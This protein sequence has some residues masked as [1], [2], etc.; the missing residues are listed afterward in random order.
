MINPT[1]ERTVATIGSQPQPLTVGHFRILM[2]KRLDFV[3]E[4]SN[5]ELTCAAVC[6]YYL[7]HGKV[8]T[9]RR[10]PQCTSKG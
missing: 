9:P 2:C 3:M 8:Q 5:S 10:I 6:L 7:S 1:F 4:I